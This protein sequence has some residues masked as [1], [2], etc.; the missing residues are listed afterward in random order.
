MDDFNERMERRRECRLRRG[1]NVIADTWKKLLSTALL[2]AQAILRNSL[3]SL[4]ATDTMEED[5]V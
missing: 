2:K 4:R 1:T 3:G 5:A